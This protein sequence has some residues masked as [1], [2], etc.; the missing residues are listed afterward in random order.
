MKLN[1]PSMIC[2]LLL[3]AISGNSQIASIE[4]QTGIDDEAARRMG[5]YI[6]GC[7]NCDCKCGFPTGDYKITLKSPSSGKEL[8]VQ[9]TFNDGNDAITGDANW[10]LNDQENGQIVGYHDCEHAYF[11]IVQVQERR[12]I[13]TIENGQQHD[14]DDA[15]VVSRGDYVRDNKLSMPPGSS[16]SAPEKWVCKAWGSGCPRISKMV[17]TC[18]YSDSTGTSHVTEVY[19]GVLTK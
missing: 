19:Y 3:F 18:S 15:D 12:R 17:A 13:A 9:F 14:P 16:S 11:T 4:E 5:S 8:N 6:Q 10:K 1:I 2:M 7:N